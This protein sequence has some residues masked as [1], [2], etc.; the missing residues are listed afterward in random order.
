ML[1]RIVGIV[2][3]LAISV[4]TAMAAPFTYSGAI[5]SVT[6]TYQAGN[7]KV[8]QDG[9]EIT[10]EQ[11]HRFGP[12]M[13]LAMQVAVFD[14]ATGAFVPNAK[15]TSDTSN[16]TGTMPLVGTDGFYIT[17]NNCAGTNL[18]LRA[19]NPVYTSSGAVDNLVKEYIFYWPGSVA[20][21][22]GTSCSGLFSYGSVSFTIHPGSG[23]FPPGI[24]AYTYT[25]KTA[26]AFPI[27]YMTSVFD[28]S[29]GTSVVDGVWRSSISG[30][31][32]PFTTCHTTPAACPIGTLVGGALV[33]HTFEIFTTGAGDGI[34]SA[35]ANHTKMKLVA[36]SGGATY[37]PTRNSYTA[38]NFLKE[39]MVF[40]TAGLPVGK[41]RL[42]FTC[43]TLSGCTPI[44]TQNDAWVSANSVFRLGPTN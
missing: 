26:P 3:L 43:S 30:S 37:T 1:S 18:Y 32:V 24:S 15:F 20:P 39:K 36:V 42:R 8:L 40:S 19:I 13:Y 9:F 7:F 4:A 22:Y 35:F 38:V 12:G 5:Y 29:V 14:Q 17:A 16:Y 21:E 11:R 41:L 31:T 44:T 6:N 2:T 33:T 10:D 23:A 25:A 28:S 27:V 34:G